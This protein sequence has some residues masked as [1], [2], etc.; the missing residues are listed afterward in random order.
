MG[1]RPG[2]IDET[3]I[4]PQN[5]PG[6]QKALNRGIGIGIGIEKRA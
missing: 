1:T 6:N 2:I 5:Y 4:V 3:I